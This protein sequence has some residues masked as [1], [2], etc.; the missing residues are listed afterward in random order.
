MLYIACI[1]SA[2]CGIP[3]ACLYV[4]HIC[5]HICDTIACVSTDTLIV[6]KKA[7]IL[8]AG[9]KGKLYMNYIFISRGKCDV[10][11][12]LKTFA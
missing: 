5:R 7:L 3:R 10:E 6:E 12:I 11:I 4:I 9:K 1:R 8:K 2:L